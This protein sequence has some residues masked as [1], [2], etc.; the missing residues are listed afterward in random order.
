MT[1]RRTTRCSF[2]TIAAAALILALSA[3]GFQPSGTTLALITKVVRDV[4]LRGESP[5]WN[6]AEK[7][8]VLKTGDRVKT[9]QQSLA[10]LKFN[11]RS[12]VRVR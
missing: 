7:G 6:P 3:F 12:I 1:F 2:R 8:A 10:I 5:E 11:D 4:S 9:G